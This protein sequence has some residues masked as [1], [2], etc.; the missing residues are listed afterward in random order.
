MEGLDNLEGIGMSA[1]GLGFIVG[2]IAVIVIGAFTMT[3]SMHQLDTTVLLGIGVLGC[4]WLAVSNWR[5]KQR[6]K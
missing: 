1:R 3:G 2:M 5:N 4:F 6:R